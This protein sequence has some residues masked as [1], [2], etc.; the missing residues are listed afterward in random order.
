MSQNKKTKT[1]SKS[2]ATEQCEKKKIENTENDNIHEMV[3]MVDDFAQI[4]SADDFVKGYQSSTGLQEKMK[5]LMFIFDNLCKAAGVTEYS[6]IDGGYRG[7]EIL[8]NYKQ[9]I[10]ASWGDK[11]EKDS[12]T[13]TITQDEMASGAQG[14]E[15]KRR[16]LSE[17][18][19]R[20]RLL[21]GQQPR[22]LITRD[23]QTEY[24]KHNAAIEYGSSDD[25][26]DDII[27]QIL[28]RSSIAS[29]LS[30]DQNRRLTHDESDEDNTHDYHM[31]TLAESDEENIV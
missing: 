14:F 1:Q 15:A 3:E 24:V 28:D 8:N 7:D 31:S 13:K 27:D 19:E 12:K 30:H 16:I 23:G 2:F 21:L 20:N 26:D 22:K 6:A 5:G 11:Q 29:R 9:K 18:R 4:I 10:T 25:G 17:K